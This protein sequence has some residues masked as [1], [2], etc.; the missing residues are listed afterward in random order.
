MAKIHLGKIQSSEESYIPRD[1]YEELL[2]LCLL[3]LERDSIDNFSFRRPRAHHRA[4]W[5]S[6]AVNS[7][8]IVL[9]QS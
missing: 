6:S 7:L 3:Y 1:D 5:M 9:L 2:K 4:R 8:K